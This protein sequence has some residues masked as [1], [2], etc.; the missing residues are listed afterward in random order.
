MNQDVDVSADVEKAAQALARMAATTGRQN[1]IF[2][3]G[4]KPSC[5]ERRDPAKDQQRQLVDSGVV[6]RCCARC[7]VHQWIQ[8]GQGRVIGGCCKDPDK[9][10]LTIQGERHCVK[11]IA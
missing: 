4:V 1:V 9:E 3:F 7:P 5:L 2:A 8:N 6:A 10:L 11:K